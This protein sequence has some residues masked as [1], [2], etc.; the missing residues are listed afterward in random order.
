MERW[1]QSSRRL[2]H[3]HTSHPHYDVPVCALVGVL[4]SSSLSSLWPR[5]AVRPAAPRRPVGRPS[6]QHETAPGGHAPCPLRR[7]LPQPLVSKTLHGVPRSRRAL[8]RHRVSEHAFSSPRDPPDH[9]CQPCGIE[10]CRMHRLWLVSVAGTAIS[11]CPPLSQATAQTHHSPSECRPRRRPRHICTTHHRIGAR[12]H[13]RRLSETDMCPQV[14]PCDAP[15]GARGV[16]ERSSDQ[17]ITLRGDYC[18]TFSALTNEC[19]WLSWQGGAVHS[20]SDRGGDA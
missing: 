16:I 18:L 5:S 17:E 6:L 8:D 10:P 14:C 11:V 4:S 1:G 12:A 15:Q 2:Q 20:R 3:L 13:N 7:G 19:S 9:R